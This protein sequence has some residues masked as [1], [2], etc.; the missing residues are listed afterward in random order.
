VVKEA[1]FAVPGDLA[2]PTGGYTYDRRIIAELPALGWRM[3]VLNLGDGLPRPTA[4]TR[5]AAH[6]Q[7]AALEGDPL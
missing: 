1:V 2:T 7:L 4:E 3:Q 5:A 6:E